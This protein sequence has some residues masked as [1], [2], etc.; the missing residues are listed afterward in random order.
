LVAL[1]SKNKIFSIEEAVAQKQLFPGISLELAAKAVEEAK[2]RATPKW[3]RRMQ[4]FL[5]EGPWSPTK[6][7]WV[8]FDELRAQISGTKVVAYDRACFV[9]S[10]VEVWVCV[11]APSSCRIIYIRS[12]LTDEVYYGCYINSKWH[13]L[14]GGSDPVLTL[15]RSP[16]TGSISGSTINHIIDKAPKDGIDPSPLIKSVLNKARFE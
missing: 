15:N 12:N 2:A 9:W 10:P 11:R 16:Y 1:L 5:A 14:E 7:E 6:S 13:I 8:E 3:E 4:K